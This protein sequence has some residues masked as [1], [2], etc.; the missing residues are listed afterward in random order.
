MTKEEFD[1]LSENA[2]LYKVVEGRKIENTSKKSLNRFINLEIETYGYTQ[3]EAIEILTD[4]VFTEKS[5][6]RTY[7]GIV[8][9]REIDNLHRLAVENNNAILNDLNVKFEALINR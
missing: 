9:Y 3:K 2:I 8:L 6:A 5:K 7:L 4:A 1:G